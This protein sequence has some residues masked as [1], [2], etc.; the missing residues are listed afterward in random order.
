MTQ[1]RDNIGVCKC[2]WCDNDAAIRKD[3]KSKLFL[4]CIEC[5]LVKNTGPIGQDYI[6][7]NGDFFSEGKP[8]TGPQWI[9][10]NWSFHKSKIMLGKTNT[11]IPG[12]LPEQPA[13]PGEPAEPVEPEGFG[14]L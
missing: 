3:N 11:D 9:V 13:E 4:F 10:E 8:K 1:K 2:R 14:F 12:N 5:Q 7:K 6:L